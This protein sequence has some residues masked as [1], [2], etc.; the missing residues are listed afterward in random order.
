V[1]SALRS[2]LSAVVLLKVYSANVAFH[3]TYFMV[4][5]HTLKAYP[6]TQGVMDIPTLESRFAT[7]IQADL[8]HADPQSLPPLPAS[9]QVTPQ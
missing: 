7:L 6:L 8:D 4:N 5:V 9:S 2:P 1:E 3:L